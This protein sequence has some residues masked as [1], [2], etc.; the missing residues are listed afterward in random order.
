MQKKKLRKDK[1]INLNT[2]K[3]DFKL[4]YSINCGVKVTDFRRRYS[5]RKDQCVIISLVF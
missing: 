5:D 4:T 1:A 3:K 2:E